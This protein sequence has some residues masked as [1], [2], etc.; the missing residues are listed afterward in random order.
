M[1]ADQS[2]PSA[3]GSRPIYAS[4]FPDIEASACETCQIPWESLCEFLEKN[5][6]PCA[7][8]EG[9]SLFNFAQ[10]RQ[11]CT[12]FY[13]SN[14]LDVG[15][16][17]IDVD[18]GDLS[19]IEY[20]L[21]ELC[22]ANLEFLF[23]T[24]WS[25]D[26]AR[27]VHKA[28]FWIPFDAPVPGDSYKSIYRRA[29]ARFAP[30]SDSHVCDPAR[31][32]YRPSHH[33]SRPYLIRRF[34]GQFL[35]PVDIG[36]GYRQV[37][38]NVDAT[39]ELTPEILKKL[40]N[41]WANQ[42][43]PA[44]MD[45]GARLQKVLKGL[46]FAGKGERDTIAFQLASKIVEA[47]PDA[48]ER[49]IGEVF[50]QSLD[51]M[52]QE[53][54]DGALTRELLEAKVVNARRRVGELRDTSVIAPRRQADITQHFAGTRNEPYTIPE[55]SEI[56]ETVGV[57]REQ[58]DR[59]WILA[60]DRSYYV[61]SGPKPRVQECS[62]ESLVN[63]ARVALAPAPV[64]TY[65][66]TEDAMRLLTWSEL[67]ERYSTPIKE[68]RR[69][70]IAQV[71]TIE[72]HDSRLTIPVCPLRDLEPRYDTRVAK[73]L[74]ILGGPQHPQLLAW[75]HFATDLSKP[76]AALVM[77]GARSAGKSLLMR[78]LARIWT[79][80]SP[81]TLEQA[82]SNFNGAVECCPIVVSDESL[83][84]DSRGREPIAQLRQLIQSTNRTSNRKYR[85]EQPLDGAIRLVLAANSHTLL[86]VHDAL[87][88]DDAPAFAE[89]LFE[90]HTTQ[91]SREYLDSI[92]G[93]AFIDSDW[94]DQDHLA[95]HILWLVRNHPVQWCGR[96]GVQ[97]DSTDL[98]NRLIVRGGVRAQLCEFF[99]RAFAD[100][101]EFDRRSIVRAGGRLLVPIDCVLTNWDR[102]L[103]RINIPPTAVVAG[104]LAGISIGRVDVNGVLWYEVDC[105]KLSMWARDTGYSFSP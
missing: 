42:K 23:H 7:T 98:A 40:A 19:D 34:R 25:H 16:I 27:G 54:P 87:S 91:A 21:R 37:F 64:S 20:T 52:A 65:V 62:R 30:R 43:S 18:T 77:I 67:L 96:F 58:L 41:R 22:K 85:A 102:V 53:D 9:A 94:I 24:T 84:K 1:P 72:L 51:I 38:A 99:V 103:R 92:G 32:F 4:F 86:T 50:A 88:G 79:T 104:A 3:D 90:L 101:L 61:L 13:S 59:C 80:A 74:E 36:E 55:V 75:L 70:M 28:R 12:H 69:S 10:Y 17:G 82:L 29:F 73:W 66:A 31:R 46:P 97:Q 11:G 47:Y 105:A 83:P 15:A 5:V 95:Q 76:L 6:L 33:P 57:T 56:A 35:R 89:R 26:P 39:R 45:L 48:H 14:V 44:T 2:G 63:V 60:A 78:G 8:K 100:G 68:V 49:S 93:R 81:P 71:P